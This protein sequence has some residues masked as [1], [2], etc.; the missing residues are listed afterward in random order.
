MRESILG[1]AVAEDQ[2][3]LL[4]TRE[5]EERRQR[6][7]RSGPGRRLG[8]YEPSPGLF[9]G[10]AIAADG[11]DTVISPIRKPAAE[12]CKPEVGGRAIRAASGNDG[13]AR[14]RR[15]RRR[16]RAAVQGG[17]NHEG[18]GEQYRRS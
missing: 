14:R 2:P 9:L 13:D 4:H 17:L 1:A 16:R 11:R 15:R 10:R 6:I 7:G 12:K 3:N 8:C 18:D 5:V